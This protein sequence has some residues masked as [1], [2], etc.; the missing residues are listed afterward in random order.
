M[1]DLIKEITNNN[2]IGNSEEIQ[3]VRYKEYGPVVNN[4]QKLTFVEEVVKVDKMLTAQVN[5]NEKHPHNNLINNGI[6]SEFQR[7]IEQNMLDE[8]KSK[9]VEH[10]RNTRWSRLIKKIFNF[11]VKDEFNFDIFVDQMLKFKNENYSKDGINVIISSRL[12]HE[13]NLYNE[14]MEIKFGFQLNNKPSSSISACHFH[15]CIMR[16]I[17]IFI[18][19][20]DLSTDNHYY[21]F[22]NKDDNSKL[23]VGDF[24]RHQIASPTSRNLYGFQLNYKIHLTKS[25][26]GFIKYVDIKKSFWQKLLK[27]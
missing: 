10:S 8:I 25:F 27:F 24:D 11:N 22:V 21:Q 15:G 5:I 13:S 17:N 14:L 7:T 26:N 2:I 6:R 3:V 19:N 1:T 20:S 9:S 18:D 12:F 23:F 16:N 4:R